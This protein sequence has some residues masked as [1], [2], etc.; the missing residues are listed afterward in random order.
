LTA[1]TAT[2]NIGITASTEALAFIAGGNNLPGI[3]F[4]YILWS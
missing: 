4:S 2:G 1:A 3:L